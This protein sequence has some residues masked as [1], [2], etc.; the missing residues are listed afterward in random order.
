MSSVAVFAVVWFLFLLLLG[1]VGF[2]GYRL[3]TSGER[4]GLLWP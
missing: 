2:A 1:Y 3:Y 4:P